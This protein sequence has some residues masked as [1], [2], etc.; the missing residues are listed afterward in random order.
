MNTRRI[1][2]GLEYDGSRFFGFQSQRRAD[3]PTVQECVERALSQVADEPIGLVCAGRTDSGVH[4][5]GQVIHFETR[6]ERDARGWVRG[7]NSLAGPAVTAHWAQEVPMEFHAR[8]S[9][10]SRRYLYLWLDQP[11]SPAVGRELLT[12]THLAL[13]AERMTLRRHSWVSTISARFGRAD[14]NLRRLIGES[15]KW[16]CAAAL[17]A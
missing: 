17:G 9:A 5:T 7:C 15:S 12:W 8:F 10:T 1:A 3:T 14:V 2:V 4:A 11:Q 6:A 16:R 13:D